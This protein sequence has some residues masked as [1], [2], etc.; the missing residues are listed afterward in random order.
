MTLELARPAAAPTLRAVTLRPFSLVLT[1]LL[2][3]VSAVAWR[4]G[5]FYEG[6][7]DVVVVTKAVL[8]VVA[9]GIAL[10]TPRPPG[11]WGR[12]RAA[13]VIWLA[14]YLAI[15]VA[16][17]ILNADG[18]P[19]AVL[20]ARLALLALALVL[21]TV[22][23]PWQDVL[24]ALS[25][26]MVILAGVGAVTGVGS[27]AET[28]R[29]YGGIP[30]LNANVICLLLS[31]PVLLLF[32]KALTRVASAREVAAFV[33]LL[34]VI[35]L[36][37]SRTGLSV[38]LVVLALL[39]VL[40]PRVRPPMVAGVVVAATSLLLVAVLTPYVAAFA[41]RGTL[42]DITT[43]NSRTVAWSAAADY[44][45]TLSQ[46]LFGSGLALK[47]IP[48]TALYRNEQILDSSWV[49]ALL[50]VGYVGSAVLALLVLAALWHAVHLPSPQRLLVAALIVLVTL[51]GVLESGL[52][53]TAPAFI[54]LFTATVIAYRLP[55]PADGRG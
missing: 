6:G 11:A 21:V 53:D 3:L 17:G 9:V 1:F 4:R 50:Q 25:S 55:E 29:L 48:V 26:A 49:S 37:G 22:T 7:L 19:A 39:F 34:A 16:G 33:P 13:P 10:L 43:L 52:F 54:V 44:A 32:W 42:A 18:L 24:S 23:H 46:Q 31:V 38:L 51:L 12:V 8:T 5:A 35:W 28:G 47:Q 30:P 20:A 27:L 2:L 41:G 45:D 36:T 14:T 40:T 15:S